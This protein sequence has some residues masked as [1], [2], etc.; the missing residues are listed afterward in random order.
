MPRKRNGYGDGHE[1]VPSKKPKRPP[2]RN[3]ASPNSLLTACK[4]LSDGRKNAIDEMD[5][6]S[7]R[8]IKCGHP[9]SFLSEWL[10]RL[11]EPKS[12][13]VVVPGRGRIPVNEESVHRVMGVPRGRED[14]PYN[15]PTEADIELGIEMFGELGHTP[16][17]TDVLDLITSSV[18]IDEKF[19]PMW[20][21]LAGNIVI[22]PTTSNKISPRWY[23][24]LLLYIDAI[25]LTGLG[26]AL[27]D[28]AFAINVWTKEKISE[29]LSR[30]V[31]AD[32]ISY[33]KL[34]LK[35]QF[36]ADFCLFG[37]LQGLGK[38]MRVHVPPNCSDEK[39]AK[40]SELVGRFS[41]ALV[42][43]LGDLVQ[44]FISLDDEGSSHVSHRLDTDLRGISFGTH[45]MA[46]P[47][48]ARRTC[49][50]DN[51][52][53]NIIDESDT[54]NETQDNDDD[55]SDDDDDDTDFQVFYHGEKGHTGS[56]SCSG[57][58]N[59]ASGSGVA[60][61]DA[62][63]KPA[64]LSDRD[65]HL[66]VMKLVIQELG[67]RVADKGAGEV[68]PPSTQI[69]QVP[70][71]SPSK[72]I[73]TLEASSSIPRSSAPDKQVCSLEASSTIPRSAS[74]IKRRLLQSL[75]RSSG[76]LRSCI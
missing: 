18:N 17:M 24:V 12:R 72:Q 76:Y 71:R 2:P 32:E 44:G 73:G 28:G 42:G 47:P 1:G 34:P 8:E 57:A 74:Q 58:V 29:V 41:S 36:G 64:Q 37:G 5:F 20:L 27:P 62:P 23:G 13:E 65:I 51:L 55:D 50:I 52:G 19:K 7:L 45:N 14:V 25:D 38:F 31:Q 63:P 70:R 33:G 53:K 35:P 9:F 43:L 48:P 59:V 56:S 39:L 21:M 3:R 11:Y 26:I 16:K 68:I 49:Q 46:K 10:A 69:K 67:I 66:S 15:L 75:R 60:N 54:D 40:A 30:D 6:K 22:A 4:G 61:V